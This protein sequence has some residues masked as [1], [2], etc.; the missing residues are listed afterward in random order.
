MTKKGFVTDFMTI[1]IDN[2]ITPYE[3]ARY[4]EIAKVS[5]ENLEV[6]F[7]KKSETNRNWRFL[8]KINFKYRFLDNKLFELIKLLHDNK[9]KIDR[10]IVCGW[11]CLI[12]L[13]AFWFCKRNRIRF[14]LWSGSTSYEKSWLRILTIPLVKF[15]V[16][17][18]DDY[19][20]YG[21]RAKEYLIWLGAK[22]EKIK[23]FLNSIDVEFFHKQSI[24]LKKNESNLRKKYGIP[25]N[26]K[27]IIFAGQL[28]ERKGI[29]E[30]LD[31]FRQVTN[32]SITLV[33]AGTGALKPEI[34]S[35]IRRHKN[36]K[37]RLL[38]FIEYNKL[39]EVYALSDALILPS[40]EEVWGLVVNEAL[41]SGVPVL[42]SKFVGSSADLVDN[43]NGEIIKEISAEGIAETLNRFVKKKGKYII[44]PQLLRKM[45]NKTYVK[46]MF[47]N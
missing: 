27:V 11:D 18:S 41:A 47:T 40:R 45:K 43:N 33:I 13:Y 39:P 46:D 10:I 5:G 3:I 42:V 31:G 9:N 32:S 22:A 25:K 7:R 14:T 4:N 15:I 19:I 23:I 1:I 24:R 6:W 29:R 26:G 8:P 36:A 28:I 12:Y 16:S 20:A 2:I 34:E 35:Y 30:L 44:S 17:L 37:I 21:T 38:G